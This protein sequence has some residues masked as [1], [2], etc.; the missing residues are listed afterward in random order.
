MLLEGL[1]SLLELCVVECW[2]AADEAVDL[3][4][5]G[6]RQR[7]GGAWRAA[8]AAAQ[9]QAK[10]RKS[11]N[12]PLHFISL[13]NCHGVREGQGGAYSVVLKAEAA[14][15][16]RGGMQRWSVQTLLAKD[17]LFYFHGVRGGG[18]LMSS[19]STTIYTGQHAG[20]LDAT[21]NMGQAR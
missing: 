10:T 7:R 17:Q 11:Q 12:Y 14:Q 9:A 16:S 1:G 21:G 6:V 13:H 4:H 3:A 2:Q 5:H 8:A 20:M 18:G 15:T 19:S